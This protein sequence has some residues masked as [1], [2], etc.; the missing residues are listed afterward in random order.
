M[1]IDLEKTFYFSGMTPLMLAVCGSFPLTIKALLDNGADKTI[2]NSYSMSALQI[3]R[4]LGDFKIEKILDP[5]LN[6]KSY[7]PPL[8]TPEIKVFPATTTENDDETFAKRKS[9]LYNS[10]SDSLKFK[11]PLTP[12]I[13]ISPKSK[14]N[15]A[16]KKP[17]GFFQFKNFRR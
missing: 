11:H 8:C 16:H 15:N 10:L 9:E 2:L 12:N 7:K 17:K 3:A 1:T 6:S 5:F 4:S 14:F 13:C